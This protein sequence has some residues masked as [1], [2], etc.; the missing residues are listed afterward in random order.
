[1][2]LKVGDLYA[3]M[4]IDDSGFN[5]AMDRIG[6]SM[7]SAGEGMKNLGG[8]LTK[9]ITGPMAALGGALLENARRTGDYADEILD[10][11][12]ATGLSTDNL[13]EYRAVADRAGTSTDAV[14]SSQQTL[15]RQMG[16]G[17]DGSA[18]LRRGLEE[19]GLSMEDIED[20]S[21]DEQM[22]ILMDRLRGVEDEG[23]RAQIGN[24]V[25]R[26]SYED[27]API[28][29][30]NAEQMEEVTRQARESGEVM[31]G[32]SLEAANQFREGLD[33]LRS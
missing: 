23:E 33:E 1:M 29:D 3:E 14:A 10:L 4:S 7:R 2:G 11:S 28:L 12:A 19:L 5:S 16:R 27:L 17:E 24:Q 8:N 9:M 30:M 18:S 13:Q 31:D 15:V 22:E 20:A 32:E 26:G 21:P 6:G 25:L